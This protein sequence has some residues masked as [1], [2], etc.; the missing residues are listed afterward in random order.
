MFLGPNNEQ[1]NDAYSVTGTLS[2]DLSDSD[3]I[4]VYGRVDN[5]QGTPHFK[6]KAGD[7][8]YEERTWLY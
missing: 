5:D 7:S 4:E 6:G 3:Y 2:L 1:G 8:P